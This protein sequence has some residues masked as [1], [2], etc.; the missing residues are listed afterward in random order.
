MKY[1][2]KK[3]ITPLMATFLLLSF[4]V[5]VSIVVINLGRAEIEDT[6]QCVL[7]INLQ[8]TTIQGRGQ[9]CYDSSQKE[10]KFTID[11][12]VNIKV[13][14]LIVN[15]I[16]TEKAESFEL[17]DARIAK[18]GSYVGHLTYDALVDGQI[19][20]IKITPKIMPYDEELICQEKALIIESVNPC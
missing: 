2:N 20:Q 15:I 19:Q 14:G 10:V 3:A 18:A 6:A 17:N 13:E 9:V 12:G 5:A 16:G 1:L 4:A 11:N 7:D 8:L